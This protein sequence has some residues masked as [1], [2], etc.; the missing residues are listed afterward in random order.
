[1]AKKTTCP[2]TRKG[3]LSKA[4]PL[5]ITING[6]PLLAEVKDFTTG[7]LGWY[8][9]TKVPIEVDG[10]VVSVQVGVNMIIVGS[11]DLPKDEEAAGTE[12]E[13]SE[14]PAS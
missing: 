2:V 12:P 8:L 6:M 3:F 13:A 7:S 5:T 9:N 1:M 4:K 10:V 11:K 14:E